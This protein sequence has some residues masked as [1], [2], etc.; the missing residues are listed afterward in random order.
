MPMIGRHIEIRGVVQGVGFRPWVYQLALRGGVAGTVRNDSSGVIIDAFGSD[1]AVDAFLSDLSTGAPPAANVRSIAWSEIPWESRGGF[2]IVAS[3]R[4]AERNVSIPA[5][6]ATCPDCLGEV[7]DPS[8]RRYLYPFT[9]CTNCGP[10]YT[11]VRGVPYDRDKTTMASFAMCADCR[12]EYEDPLDRRFHAQPNACPVCGPRLVAVTPKGVEIATTQPIEFAARTIGATMIVAVKGLGGFHLACDATSPTAVARLRQ[13]KGREAKPLAVMVRDLDAARELADLNAA[14]TALLSSAERPIVLVRR[15][16]AAALAQGVA[17]DSPLVGLFLPYTPLHHMLLRACGRPLVMTSGN[18]SDEPMATGNDDALARLGG[19]ADLFLLHDRAIE[20]RA[21]DSVVR[22]IAGAPTV[23]RRGRGRVPGGID[24]RRP[25]AAPVLAV[26]AHLKNAICIGTGAQAFLG[27]HIGDLET[28][29][30]LKSFEASVA[31][32]KQFVGAEP[33]VVAHDLHPDYFSTRFAQSLETDANG[34]VLVPV[35]HHHAHVA[36]AMAEH[37]LEGP[38]IGV[39]YDGTGFGTDGTS[40]GA[41]VLI[42]GYEEFTR[43]ATFR[44]IPLAG[45]DQAIRQVWRIALA[46][47]DDAFDGAPPLDRMPLFAD[48]DLPVDQVRTMIARR[49]NSPRARGI[50][51]YFDAFGAIGLGRDTARY[52]GEVAILWNDVADVQESGRYEVVVHAGRS[53]WEI[54]PRPMVRAAVLELIGG[55]SPAVVSARFHNTLAAVTIE[56][57]RAAISQYGDLPVVL[58]GGCF[59]NAML[60]ERVVDGLRPQRLYLNHQIPPGDGG[61]ALG[62][63]VIADAV[64]RRGVAESAAKESS[65]CV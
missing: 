60:A 51:R 46:L 16:T 35:Q 14:E 38:V 31:Q 8:N 50:G 7:F 6:L 15:R 27:P 62:Q 29:E 57:I 48:R 10:R 24:V 37:G 47:L 12:R 40:W 55:V 26:G 49:F 23:L 2:A 65:A 64:V 30:T 43:F 32:M 3:E 53:P 61:L 54:D 42:A 28:L 45:G 52:E 34:P 39:A 19:I 33:A 5:D 9:N 17:G 56:M 58:T 21:D 4:A 36:S 59:Q 22:I 41:E 11:I 18:V 63:A 13:R 20:T 25:F 1:A 44:A